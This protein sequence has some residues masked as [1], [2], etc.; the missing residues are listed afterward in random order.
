MNIFSRITDIFSRTAGAFPLLC[1]PE[2]AGAAPPDPADA[3]AYYNRGC[4]YYMKGDYDKAIANYNEAIRINPATAEA[5]V[6]YNRGRVYYFGKKDY[7]KAIADYTE[8]IQPDP[9]VAEV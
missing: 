2:P 1:I 7:D 6:Y 4:T 3:E 8:A 5:H 9:A